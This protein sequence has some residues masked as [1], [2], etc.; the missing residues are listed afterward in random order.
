MPTPEQLAGRYER[1]QLITVVTVFFMACLVAFYALAP[2]YDFS[3][4]QVLL[5][6]VSMDDDYKAWYDLLNRF[7]YM[8]DLSI[9]L[10]D[11]EAHSDQLTESIE[12]EIDKLD[13]KMPELQVRE[14]I[15]ALSKDFTE[16]RFIPLGDMWTRGLAGLQNCCGI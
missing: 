7:N 2:A 15:D 6:Q 16:K 14:Y 9:D 12:A 3:K 10:S 8:F 5:Q 11:L 4:G 1:R 13:E